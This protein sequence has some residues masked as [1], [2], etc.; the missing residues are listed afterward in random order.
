MFKGGRAFLDGIVISIIQITETVLKK[1]SGT[2]HAILIILG[3]LESA[4]DSPE[5]FFELSN[6]GRRKP[7]VRADEN[8]VF[9]ALRLENF[10]FSS[11]KI[12]RKYACWGVVLQDSEGILVSPE[13]FFDLGASDKGIMKK[14]FSEIFIEY[15]RTFYF[16]FVFLFLVMKKLMNYISEVDLTIL[17]MKLVCS[18][19][20]RVSVDTV[21]NLSSF[22]R[23]LYFNMF[24]PNV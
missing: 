19:F 12:A 2:T 22:H 23:F 15:F 7:L 10:D 20:S 4:K 1:I 9:L 17:W 5:T 14:K 16:L 11:K 21:R 13:T 18:H 6:F 24:D 8:F 3:V